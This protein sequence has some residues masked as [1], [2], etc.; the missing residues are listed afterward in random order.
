MGR[1]ATPKRLTGPSDAS[2]FRIPSPPAT[3]LTS[4]PPTLQPELHDARLPLRE[5]LRRVLRRLAARGQGL[6]RLS[7]LHYE[8]ANDRLSTI[9]C[10]EFRGEDCWAAAPGPASLTSPPVPAL[11]APVASDPDA[12]GVLGSEPS[13]LESAPLAEQPWL[14]GLREPLVQNHLEGALAAGD[15]RGRWLRQGGWRS[16]LTLPLFRDGRL[17]G[18]LILDSRS[19]GSFDADTLRDLQPHLELLLQRIGDHLCGTATLQATLG[20]VLEIA[21]LRHQETAAHLKRVSGYSRAIALRLERHRALPA[22]LGEDLYRFAAFHDV[23]KIGIPDSVLLKQGP[24]T[25]VE[26][27]LMRTH[28]TIGSALIERVITA[29]QLQADPSMEVLRQVVAH[30]HERLDGSGYP[31]GLRGEAISLA[32]RIVAVADIFDA[33]TQERVYKPAFSEREA[34][35]C[36]HQMVAAGKLDRACVACLEA[37]QDHRHV[38]REHDRESASLLPPDGPD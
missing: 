10:E 25:E 8:P 9:L 26:E 38:I 4:V 6:E 3:A 34:M 18:F 1:M 33:L 20:L 17:L 30:H 21:G 37:V 19:A 5:L 31:L 16:A 24:L 12:A 13:P 7:F 28:V 36:L 29:L 2:P 27:R 14:A 35:D 15:P 32:G 11:P 23:G 22:H